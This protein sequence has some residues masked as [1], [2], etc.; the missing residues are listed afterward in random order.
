MGSKK[1]NI[2]TRENQLGYTL[3]INP[4]TNSDV[5]EPI[6]T[7]RYD[8]SQELLGNVLTTIKI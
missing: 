8:I 1:E 2:L 6:R 3:R 5:S 4:G 7:L